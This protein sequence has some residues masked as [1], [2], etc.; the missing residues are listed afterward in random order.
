M[1]RLT[2]IVFTLVFSV[3]V[4]HVVSKEVDK[5]GLSESARDAAAERKVGSVLPVIQ[6]MVGQD[7][8][9]DLRGKII[10][11]LSSFAIAYT[12]CPLLLLL[13]C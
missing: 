11:L 13:R 2:M 7:G 5:A 9:C 6:T 8:C 4:C 1:V 12:V 3:L 10:F